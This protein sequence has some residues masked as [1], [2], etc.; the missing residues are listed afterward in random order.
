MFLLPHLGFKDVL[1]VLKIPYPYFI[2]KRLFTWGWSGSIDDCDWRISTRCQHS[3]DFF[4]KQE[5]TLSRGLCWHID[6]KYWISIE[7]TKQKTLS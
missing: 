6:L 2:G 3:L 4:Q 7:N 1:A 5:H